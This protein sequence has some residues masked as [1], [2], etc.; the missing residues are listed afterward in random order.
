M[1]FIKA[2]DKDDRMEIFNL[3]VV[4]NITPYPNGYT[5]IL[6]GAGLYWTVKTDSIEF[7]ECQNDLRAAIKGGLN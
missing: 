3:A 4:L 1:I 7:I 6:M 5:K 2:V